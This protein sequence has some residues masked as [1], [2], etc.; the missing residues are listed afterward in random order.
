MPVAA[1][2]VGADQFAEPV[3]VVGRGDPLRVHL[4]ESTVLSPQ[5]AAC[6]AASQPARP[7]PMT[8]MGEGVALIGLL[9]NRQ[10]HSVLCPWG[11]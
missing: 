4:V 10:G 6:Q 8:G 2:A 3:A 1:Q 9:R 7:P 11:G 5:R